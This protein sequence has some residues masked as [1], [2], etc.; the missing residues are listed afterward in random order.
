M[1][2]AALYAMGS[3]PA[4]DTVGGTVSRMPTFGPLGS[5][6]PGSPHASTLNAGLATDG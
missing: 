3:A 6:P 1:A 4:E 2:V 5:P